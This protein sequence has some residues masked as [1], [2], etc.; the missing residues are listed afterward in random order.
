MGG[1][2]LNSVLQYPPHESP[3]LVHAEQRLVL[4]HHS[5]ARFSQDSDERLF[6]QAVQRHDDR[7]ATDELR[8]HSELDQVSGLDELQQPVLLLDLGHGVRLAAGVGQVGGG[9]R[10]PPLSHFNFSVCGVQDL[11]APLLL[12]CLLARLLLHRRSQSVPDMLDP[13]GR[14]DPLDREDLQILTRSGFMS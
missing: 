11:P 10:A 7:Q 13:L 9:R 8:D 4:R 6:V 1:G 14:P 5:V 2:G 12:R 3:H